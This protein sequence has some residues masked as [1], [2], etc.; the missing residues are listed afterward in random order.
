MGIDGKDTSYEKNVGK[1]NENNFNLV[2][3]I[4][5]DPTKVEKINLIT[6]K[7]TQLFLATYLS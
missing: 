3:T 4:T 2:F 7:K 1:L 6:L 5:S